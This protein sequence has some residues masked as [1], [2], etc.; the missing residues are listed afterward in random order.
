MSFHNATHGVSNQQQKMKMMQN[1]DIRKHGKL[2]KDHKYLR[3]PEF[4]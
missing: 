1:A 3:L 4:K 2:Q